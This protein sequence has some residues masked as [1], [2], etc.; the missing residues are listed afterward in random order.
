MPKKRKS[1]LSG[2]KASKCAKTV[3]PTVPEDSGLSGCDADDVSDTEMR[4]DGPMSGSQ[5]AHHDTS[6]SALILPQTV[7]GISKAISS[8]VS[9]APAVPVTAKPTSASASIQILPI[10]LEV[11]EYKAVAMEVF[12]NA[13]GRGLCHRQI[14]DEYFDN[15]KGRS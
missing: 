9:A 15:P 8:P 12:I 3:V 1:A 5:T 13:H 14:L 7:T 4:N 6:D 2:Q 10:G 11:E